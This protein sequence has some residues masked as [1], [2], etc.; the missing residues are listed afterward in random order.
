MLVVMVRIPIG[1]AK[2]AETLEAR[3]RNRAGLVDNQPG[4]IG[5]ELLKGKDEFISVTRWATRESLDNWMQSQSHAAA[6]GHTSHPTGGGHPQSGA[7]PAAAT[8]ESSASAALTGS[9]MIYEVVIPS[10]EGA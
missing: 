6:H 4:F 2:D 10:G 8:A 5:F 1:S 7:H 3:F 9:A